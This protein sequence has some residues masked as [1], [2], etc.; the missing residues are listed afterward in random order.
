MR[1][2]AIAGGLLLLLGLALIP[3]PEAVAERIFFAGYKGGFYIRSEEEGGME[4]RLGGALQADYRRFL[5]AE[6]S[7]NRFDIRRARLAFRGQLTR[8][9]RFG[10]EYEF[11]GNEIKHLVDAYGEAVIGGVHGLRFGQFK[12]PYSLEWATRDKGHYFAE[13]SMGYHLT[14]KRDLG[15]MLHG[16]FFHDGINYG[17]GLFNG[18]GVDGAAS[19]SEHDDPEAALRLVGK[20]FQVLDIPWLA[21]FQIGG[22]A[23]YAR[24]DLANVDL[25]VK[26][27]GMVGTGKTAYALKQN[28]KFGVLQDVDHRVRWALEAAWTHG[29]VAL[30]A[31]YF[32]LG[33]SGLKPSGRPARDADFSAWYAAAMVCLTGEAPILTGGVMK[34]I[35]PDRFF[36]PAEGTFGALCLAARLEHFEGDEAWINPDAKVS[37]A[38][39]DAASVAL[40]WILYPMHRMVFDFTH[41]DLSDPVRVRVDPDGEV[42]YVDEENVFTVRFSIDF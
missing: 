25:E 5:E 3:A 15:L 42:Q 2:N 16:S 17:V 9:F 7:D 38:E 27:T 34:P 39:A 24:I 14:P 32:R 6:R 30:M 28:T 19:G 36:N 41:T 10:I 33:Y 35:Y 11:Q 31:E 1:N 8:W 13:R 18:D 37:V 12:E 4:L 40:N 21:N 29:P 22:S 26:S 23:A 20:P